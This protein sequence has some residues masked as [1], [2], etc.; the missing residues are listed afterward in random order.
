M[1][2]LSKSRVYLCGAIDAAKDGG[3]TWRKELTPFLQELGIEIFNPCEKP[4]HLL[5]ETAES[6]KLRHQLKKQGKFDEVATLMKEIRHIDLRMV[7]VCDFLIVHLNNDIRTVGTIEEMAVSNFS[8]KPILIH[9]EQGK[10]NIPDWILGMIPHSFIFST[11]KELREYL[12]QVNDGGRVLS[13][14]E[15]DR[16]LLFYR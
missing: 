5:N 13:K 9:I 11:W 8:K 16:W 3:Q 4:T 14:Y 10:E 2:L 15:D 7:D 12:V 1:N 6:V